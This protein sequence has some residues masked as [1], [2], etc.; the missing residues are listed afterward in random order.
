MILHGAN[1]PFQLL[2]RELFNGITVVTTVA[3][4]LLAFVRIG[5]EMHLWFRYRDIP[6]N[7]VTFWEFRRRPVIRVGVGVCV[8]FAA[9]FVQRLWIFILLRM[10]LTHSPGLKAWEELW[11]VPVAGSAVSIIGALCILRVLAPEGHGRA[12]SAAAI[13]FGF[14]FLWAAL[15]EGFT[16]AV[17][18]GM[19]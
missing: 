15:P 12:A 2:M 11:W 19:F 7:P 4:A 13:V 5:W 6:A 9:E 17:M 18:S 10:N 14:I 16:T 3:I 1:F 8:F